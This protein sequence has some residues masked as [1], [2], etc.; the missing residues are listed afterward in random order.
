MSGNPM[1]NPKVF[2]NVILDAKPM[3]IS[4]AI[5]KTIILLALVIISAIGTWNICLNGFMDKA[6]MLTMGGVISAL[7]LG[8]IS[9]SNP[10]VSPITAPAFAICEGL[11]IGAISFQY[12]RLYDGIIINAFT[13]TILSM[14]TMLFLYKTKMIVATP[15]FKKV[16]VTSTIAIMIFYIAGIIGALIGHPMTIF[17]GSIIGIGVSL[18]FCVIA[19]LNFILDFDFIENG[20][21]NLLPDYFEWY[22]GLSLL[23]TLI[24][25]YLEVLRLLAQLSQ[26]D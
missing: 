14:L 4:G 24:W 26:K 2:E 18:L 11:A 10:K 9:F 3:T 15:T 21:K 17:N 16:I 8:I 6:S 13:I 7:I 12:A 19:S 1:L 23:I 20:E 22:G 5:N 25:L